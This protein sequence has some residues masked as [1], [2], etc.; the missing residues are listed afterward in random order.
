MKYRQIQSEPHFAET[1]WQLEETFPQVFRDASKA[2]TPTYESFLI[3]WQNCGE[4]WGLFDDANNL[5]AV[6]YLE[7]HTDFAVNIHVSVLKRVDSNLIVR[8]FQSLTRQKYIDG[9]TDFRAWIL[10]KNR[11]LVKIAHETNYHQTGLKMRFGQSRGKVLNW[12]EFKR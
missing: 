2:W 12:L 6:V 4:I 7:F 3:F 10:E 11:A 8:F 1:I 5:L 9:V